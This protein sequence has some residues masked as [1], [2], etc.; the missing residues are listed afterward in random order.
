METSIVESSKSFSKATHAK[1]EEIRKNIFSIYAKEF[2]FKHNVTKPNLSEN[3]KCDPDDSEKGNVKS[4][5]EKIVIHEKK[6]DISKPDSPANGGEYSNKTGSPVKEVENG[7]RPEVENES[8]AA[9]SGQSPVR[10]NT[11]SFSVADILDPGKFT[12]VKLSPKRSWHPWVQREDGEMVE[13]SD[14][15]CMIDDSGIH[16]MKLTTNSR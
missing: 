7:Q 12:G 2:D 13:E 10:V 8:P 4:D 14:E 9:R 6:N 15:E 16:N 11:T 3:A 5:Q 1:I